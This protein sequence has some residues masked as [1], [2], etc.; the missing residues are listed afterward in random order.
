MSFRDEYIKE[1]EQL[2]SKMFSN[3][4][5][6]NV[7]DF[8]LAFG[9]HKDEDA[10]NRIKEITDFTENYDDILESCKR[11]RADYTEKQSAKFINSVIA[12]N[13]TEIVN[14]GM[15]YK[16]A[17]SSSDDMK[18]VEDDCGSIGQLYSL[19][20]SKED[21]NYYIKRR[22]VTE[23]ESYI[24]SYSEFIE[25]T[26]NLTEIHV[27]TFLDCGT[28]NTHRL[29]CKKC[30]GLFRRTMESEFT[31]KYIGTYS[32]LMV[33]EKS[34]QASLDSMNKGTSKSVSEI[35][36]TKVEEEIESYEDVKRIIRDI[37]DDIG[38]ATGVDS[39]FYELI[40]L[41]RYRHGEFS[42][43]NTSFLKQSDIFGQ[44][45]YRPKNSLKKL[46]T[47][48]ETELTSTKSRLVFNDY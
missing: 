9:S 41:S 17:M 18:I 5:I 37:L 29:F 20:I 28:D 40:L 45:I 44:F 27:R 10:L 19:P 25:K 6:P 38:N 7:S 30:S 22:Y 31:P 39:R 46:I 47:C 3:C 26:E 8:A 2:G 34:T 48:G 43:L 15:L 35:L 14:S 23:L 36:N 32:S 4:Y 33:T 13:V 24:E 1:Y 42:P 21:F 16:Y 12:S 11:T